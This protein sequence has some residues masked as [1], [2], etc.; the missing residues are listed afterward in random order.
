ME[1]RTAEYRILT[2][3]RRRVESLRSD[4]FKIK[5]GAVDSILISIFLDKIDGNPSFDIRYSIVII[6]PASNALIRG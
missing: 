1:K 5:Y 2:I 3:E 4:S 6:R